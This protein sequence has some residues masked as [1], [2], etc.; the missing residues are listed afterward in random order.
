MTNVSI[1]KLYKYLLKEIGPSGW[2]PADS[3]L[4]IILGAILVQN[5]NWANADKA[6]KQLK[7]QT[8]LDPHRIL[9]LEKSR[10]Q[11][12]IYSAG[13]YKNKA[14]TIQAVFEWFQLQHW[15]Y[16][17]IAKKYD[18][19]LR[20]ELLKLRGVGQETADV[21]LVYI[22]DQVA[23]IADAYARKIFSY[24]DQRDYKNYGELQQEIQMPESFT[25]LEAQDLHGLIDNFGKRYLKDSQAMEELKATLKD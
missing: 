12:L 6:L 2:W 8:D 7:K 4:E 14:L 1:E 17:Q 9:A 18:L 15:D 20:K 16:Q 5:T 3:K 13:F 22:F 24:L 21:L 11:E 23:F 10:L 19:N 25:Y